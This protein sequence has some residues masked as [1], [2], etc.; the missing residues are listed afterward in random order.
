M[1]SKEAVC[2][3]NGARRNLSLVG[4]IVKDIKSLMQGWQGCKVTWRRRSANKAAHI[5]A[6]LPVG[7]GAC[8]EWRYAPP[9]CILS[10]I[11]D[12]ISDHV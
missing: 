3:I 9:D 1:D 10:V 11:G 6:R 2:M 12:E 5:L 4:T 7:D 8:V